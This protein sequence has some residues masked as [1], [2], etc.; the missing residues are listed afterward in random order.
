MWWIKLAILI[1][2]AALIWFLTRTIYKL[3]LSISN[4]FGEKK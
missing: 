4:D 1:P 3:A 2:L